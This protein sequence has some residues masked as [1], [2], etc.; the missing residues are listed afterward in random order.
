MLRGY[1]LVACAALMWAL[2]G[3]VSRVA[4]DAGLHPVEVSFYRTL[5][6]WPLFAAHAVRLGSITVARRDLPAMLAFGLVAIAG[7]HGFYSE[8]VIFGGAALASVLLYTAPAWVALLARLLLAEPMGAFKM[9]AVAMAVAGVALI[10]FSSAGNTIPLTTP[11]VVFGLLSGL[12]YALY[13][14]FG[15]LYLDRYPTPTAFLYALPVA[16]LAMLPFF[17]FSPLSLQGHGA[18]VVLAVVC[19]YGAF[20]V[21]YSG[22]RHLEA[23]R[24]A[25]TATLEPVAANVL[26]FVWFGEA[27][28]V[29]GYLGSALI[30]AGVGLTIWDGSRRAA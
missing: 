26:A 6:A 22:L 18:C 4:F 5:F 11:A 12:C 20:S 13:Y 15:K 17:N 27:F 29:G 19:T 1:G 3:P 24:A 9:G 21:Y 10:S 25:M 23:T 14:I 30:L 28:A 7:L 8:A 2:I 16:A